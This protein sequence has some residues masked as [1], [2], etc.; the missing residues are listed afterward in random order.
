MSGSG[1][2]INDRRQC[3]HD[4]AAGP[5][6]DREGA[7][8]RAARRMVSAS[9]ASVED[10]G[11]RVQVCDDAMSGR[12]SAQPVTPPASPPM[13]RSP[14]HHRTARVPWALTDSRVRRGMRASPRPAA[15]CRRRDS[16]CVGWVH[17]RRNRAGRRRWRDRA[18]TR[19][20]R[21]SAAPWSI[22][23]GADRHDRGHL[24]LPG[25]RGARLGARR[26]RTVRGCHATGSAGGRDR[27]RGRRL[28]AAPPG[29]HRRRS[30]STRRGRALRRRRARAVAV[31]WAG[32]RGDGERG[33][34]ARRVGA[35]RG[36]NGRRPW[37]TARARG[38][39]LRRAAARRHAAAARPNGAYAERGRDGLR[40]EDDSGTAGAAS[41][42]GGAGHRRGSRAGEG[43]PAARVPAAGADAARGATGRRDTGR[44]D[45][46]RASRNTHRRGGGGG[47]GRG[48]QGAGRGDEG[49]PSRASRPRG[50]GRMT[51]E[52]WLLVVVVVLLVLV[53][54][55]LVAPR[56]VRGWRSQRIRKRFGPEY[57]R[58]V[59]R[60]GDRAA[61][62]AEL[63]E[64]EKQRSRLTITDLDP[65]ARDR[66]L[67]GWRAA[68]ARFVDN[69]VAATREADLLV[70]N[71]MRDRGYPV[72]DF[73]QQAADVSV[74]HP[75][76]VEHYRSAHAVAVATERDQVG[77]EDL[78][79][80]ITHYRALFDELVG[81]GEAESGG[82]HG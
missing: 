38:G 59:S 69:P 12:R 35:R 36:R 71:V 22:P 27:C 14:S 1:R 15:G 81:A 54:A 73:E 57:D 44:P 65:A 26:R 8:A 30:G 61:A 13:R 23:G 49:R 25:R 79:Q 20:V 32:A 16:G 74:D 80:A 46:A 48:S 39:P 37:R 47:V 52:T 68:Q 34:G 28:R 19:C 51:M 56:A 60:T 55:A 70:T 18:S 17:T 24:P 77:T 5:P 21:G 7:N 3:A 29:D 64:R 40:H 62:E 10:P 67:Q 72:D 4:R 66:Y 45:R 78:R 43:V 9:S 75:T 11:E 2:R 41:A 42:R 82:R 31:L 50:F 6:V 63:A 58:T 33:D 76:V 53:L